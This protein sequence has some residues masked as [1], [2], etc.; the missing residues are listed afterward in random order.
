MLQYLCI[1]PENGTIPSCWSL[2][3]LHRA[4]QWP[5]SKLILQKL[6]FL[7][8][9]SFTH[10]VSP[11]HALTDDEGSERSRSNQTQ[12][13]GAVET[14]GAPPRAGPVPAA[15]HQR[16][17]S[18]PVHSG[19]PG[20]FFLTAADAICPRPSERDKNTFL[21]WHERRDDDT[22]AAR[23]RFRSRLIRIRADLRRGGVVYRLPLVAE[24]RPEGG[25]MWQSQGFMVHTRQFFSPV[26]FVLLFV[27][28][29]PDI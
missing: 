26:C 17:R 14:P 25:N 20:F 2:F 23:R 27:W 15:P 1:C 24:W 11:P 21:L 6:H 3:K 29:Q 12:V 16:G 8:I 9:Y 19:V 22:R 5:T 28:L 13:A 10:T 4:F 18:H 7:F